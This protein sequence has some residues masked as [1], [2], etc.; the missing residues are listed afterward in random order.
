MSLRILFARLFNRRH[1]RSDAD[2]K[3]EFSAHLDMSLQSSG[4]RA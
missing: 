3:E 2:L 1:R 4:R